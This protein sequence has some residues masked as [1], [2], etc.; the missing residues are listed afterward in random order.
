M[1]EGIGDAVR[2]AAE[3]NAWFG[4]WPTFHD[5][6]VLSVALE[7]NAAS[8]LRVHTWHMT[9]QVDERGYYVMTKHIVVSFVLENVT[10]CE[11]GA[12]N[13]Q[14]VLNS[15]RVERES[16]GFKVILDECYGL[17]GSI[18]AT[19]LRIELEPWTDTA[20]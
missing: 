13:R 2:G 9:N 12:F 6:E 17:N 16:K 5:A 4:Y 1:P 20:P 3:L 11:L 15:L 14:N 8:R 7:R 18:T 10:D 19:G